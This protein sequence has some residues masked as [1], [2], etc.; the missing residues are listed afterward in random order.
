MSDK[1][2]N[3]GFEVVSLMIDGHATNFSMCR[4]LG[5]SILSPVNFRS[6]FLLPGTDKKIY[7]LYDAC[8][9]LKLVRNMLE[10]YGTVWSAK[11]PKFWKFITDLHRIQQTVGLRAANKLSQRHVGFK[12]QIMKVSLTAQTLSSSVAS[13]MQLL[14]YLG[15]T[16]FREA[17]MIEFLQI[18]DRLFDTLNR[19][20]PKARGF[21]A[22]IRQTNA[23]SIREFLSTT[24][25]YLL[26]LHLEDG[27]PLYTSKRC[28]CIIAFIADIDA[29]IAMMEY[30]LPHQDYILMYKFSQDHLELFFN[31]VRRCG[32]WNNNPTANQFKYAFRRFDSSVVGL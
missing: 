16:E 28:T 18:I 23:R 14:M 25:Q 8:H 3:R 26:R 29:A 20:S 7:V 10:A 19:F 11:G 6:W 4:S 31:A 9:I 24:W 22:P 1:L 12:Q 17:A 15:F 32:G 27:T 13:I 5:C 21:K 30:L 2:H